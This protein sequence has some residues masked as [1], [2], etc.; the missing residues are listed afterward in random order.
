MKPLFIFLILVLTVTNANAQLP[1]SGVYTYNYCDIEYNKCMGKCKVRI[2]GNKVWIY[3]PPNLTG[4]KEGELYESGTLYKHKSGKWTIINLKVN[5][6]DKSVA[7]TS[8]WLR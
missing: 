5:K 8:Y 6:S 4:I 1:K 7:L 3:A 2:N